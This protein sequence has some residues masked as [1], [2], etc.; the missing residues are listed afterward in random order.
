M[1]TELDANGWELYNLDEDFA[2]TITTS[3]PS[4][5]DRLIEMI[6]MWY[7]E[8]G[9]YNVLPIDSRGTQR[10]AEERPQIAVDRNRYTLY[11]GTQSIPARRR[12]KILNRP[13]SFKAE[14][15]FLK[16]G[17]KGVLLSMGGNDGGISFYVQDGQALFAHNYVAVDYFYVKSED[18]VPTGHHFLSMEFAP[19]GKPDFTK[20]KGAPGDRQATRGRQGGRTRRACRSR[21]PIGLAQ[22]GA[23]LVGARYRRG[24]D[25]GVLSRRSGSPARSS[26]SSS[27]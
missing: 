6:G 18:A 20:G 16:A 12:P 7:V 21:R 4:D 17:A 8:A 24:G 10:F 25:S 15:E 11:P 9:K 23:M 27:T 5:R 13:Y 3:R 22:G 2:E 19:T 14:V 1:L 26:G